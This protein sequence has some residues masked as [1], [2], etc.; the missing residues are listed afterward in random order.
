VNNGTSRLCLGRGK[1]KSWLDM[2]CN[3]V[4]QEASVPWVPW[5]GGASESQVY[6]RRAGLGELLPGTRLPFGVMVHGWREHSG[7]Y[8]T[9]F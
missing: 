1:R 8:V 6:A 3:R 2:P 4:S 7:T 5:L 9:S